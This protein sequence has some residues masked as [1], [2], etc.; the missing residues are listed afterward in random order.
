VA[1]S[2]EK[3]VYRISNSERWTMRRWTGLLILG[4]VCLVIGLSNSA[5][6]F[7][8]ATKL[9]ILDDAIE[10]SPNSFRDFMAPKRSYRGRSGKN[11]SMI[12]MRPRLERMMPCP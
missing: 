8:T 3:G 4:L 11:G 2:G 7:T 10:L 1:V 9:K 6:A 12:T 5:F